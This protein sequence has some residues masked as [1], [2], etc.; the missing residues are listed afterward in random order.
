MG[1]GG[2]LYLGFMLSALSILGTVKSA[3]IVSVT[4]PVL[5]LGVPIFDTAFAILRRF[6]NKKPDVTYIKNLSH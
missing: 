6:I 1:D 4:I 3:T 2:S 5:V